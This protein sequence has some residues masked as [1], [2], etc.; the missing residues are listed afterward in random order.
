[1][2]RSLATAVLGCFLIPLFAAPARSDKDSGHG[3]A[4]VTAKRDRFG[5]SLPPAAL[6]RLGT[7]RFRHGFVTHKIAI[8]PDGKVLASGGRFPGLRFWDAETGRPLHQPAFPT[9]VRGMSF[10]QDG[11][12]LII[13][14]T[15]SVV[16][17]SSGKE[18]RR[19]QSLGGQDCLA[20][21][22]DGALVAADDNDSSI[23]L[24]D[25]AGGT[26]IRQFQGH[27]SYIL[28]VAFSPSG[29]M[30]ASAS[31]DKTVRLWDVAS[32]R[33][34][35]RFDE[36]K[37]VAAV[38]F[39][40][41]GKV[42]AWAGDQPA[43]RLW[44]MDRGVDP[45]SVDTP[46]GP[47]FAIAFS[48]DSKLLVSG[49]YDGSLTLWDVEQ[50]RIQ[51]RWSAHI[52]PVNSVAFFPGGKTLASTA[53]SDGAIRIWETATGKAIH[54]R[55]GHTSRVDIL[56]FSPDGKKLRSFARD[57]RALEWDLTSGTEKELLRTPPRLP[58]RGWPL[59]TA[60]SD[61]FQ[62]L[63]FAGCYD[64]Y[65]KSDAHV[66]VY[67]L[68][69]KQLC[70]W[71]GSSD[72]LS[73]GFALSADGKHAAAG[74]S[75]GIHVWKVS[76]GEKL[77]HLPMSH[78]EINFLTFS[79]RGE[80]LASAGRE[81][82]LRLWD[83]NTKKE[84]RHWRHQAQGNLGGGLVFSPD[85]RLVAAP[86][87]PIGVWQVSSGREF[88]QFATTDGATTLAFSPTARALAAA[89]VLAVPRPDGYDEFVGRVTV[90]EMSSGQV[91]D[92]FESKDD[93]I[94]SLQFS[95][96]GKVLASG[97]GDSTIRLWD[98]A[99]EVSHGPHKSEELNKNWEAL[100]GPA[101]RAARAIWALTADPAQVIPLLKS[102]LQP[103]SPV[104]P[105][106]INQWLADLKSERFQVREKATAQ[107]IEIAEL[108]EKPLRAAIAIPT[109]LDFRAR[110]ERLLDRLAAPISD[111]SRLRAVRAVEV[112]ENIGTTEAR[113]LLETLA[114]GAPEALL[115]REACESCRRP[116]MR[117]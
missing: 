67:D 107:L 54:P 63:A 88:R 110:V 36:K 2:S 24:W 86:G 103:V 9:S 98:L 57:L 47:A 13:G 89:E 50:M 16:E 111:P 65:G 66:R 31:R 69:G 8:S 115:T 113:A 112:L 59:A 79:S 100:R 74:G 32:G 39:S 60:V 15:L 25:F 108:A 38:A 71:N 30:L 102:R 85:D 4:K 44:R 1:M 80:L 73:R 48:P 68:T 42:L 76:A 106:R 35:R 104:D 117:R 61:N 33:Q 22:P 17:V 20:I 41:D 64:S 97:V 43:I 78:K 114:G 6:G 93:W 94:C 19:F 82:T 90:W 81:G 7:V 83:L 26:K 53:G 105:D 101:P 5:D 52:Y 29:K 46:G 23:D 58:F 28:N 95:P 77:A 55:V 51:R 21:S 109:S 62:V 75:D 10:S 84:L 3:S 70:F 99:A 45:Q 96:E 11:K 12:F 87:S 18:V 72:G 37:E 14:G 56:R 27:S 49:G 91:I 116:A 34:L 92:R 40:P